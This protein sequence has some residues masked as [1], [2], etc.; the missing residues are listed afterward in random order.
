MKKPYLL[1]VV[2]IVLLAAGWLGLN[3]GL[4]PA[5][6]EQVRLAVQGITLPPDGR[7][8]QSSAQQVEFSP[9]S[10]KLTITGLNLRGNMPDGPFTYSVAEVTLDVPLRMLPAFTPLRDMALPRTGM[11]PVA[12]NITLRNIVWRMPAGHGDVQREEI[13]VLR[14]ESGLIARVLDGQP[15]SMLEAAY[16]MGADSA[17]SFSITA[18]T[19]TTAVKTTIR[20]TAVTGWQ[21]AAI[22]AVRLDG[23]LVAQN[24]KEIARMAGVVCKDIALPAPGLMNRLMD[25]VSAHGGDTE[26]LIDSLSP[27]VDEMTTA[28][29]PLLGQARADGLVL[30]DEGNS[31]SLAEIGYDRLS[32]APRHIGFFLRGLAV[33]HAM[34]VERT[35]LQLPDITLELLRYEGRDQSNASSRQSLILKAP[36]LADIDCAFTRYDA[37]PVSGEQ[38]LLLQSFS[39]LSLDIQDLGALAWLGRNLSADPAK[40]AAA[41]RNAVAELEFEASPRNDEL[42]ATLLNFINHP[43]KLEIRTAR[44][45]RIGLALLLQALENP[46]ALLTLRAAPGP[47]TLEEQMRAL[48]ATAPATPL[49]Q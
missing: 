45:K 12:E 43:G 36:G 19:P 31:I 48:P 32:S 38:A 20:E 28:G 1:I 26:A 44:N 49:Q 34:L 21:G 3:F 25:A 18:D 5:V 7:P 14:A 46:A 23:L 30:S 15:V 39:D 22:A 40:A 37:G 10:R 24:G 27:I 29:T 9:F 13:D 8:S 47:H 42:R 41:L 4:R 6:E 17:R 2:P 16:H 35:E 33:P 11:T